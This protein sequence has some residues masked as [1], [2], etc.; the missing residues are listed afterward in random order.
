MT[1]LESESRRVGWDIHDYPELVEFHGMLSTP[2]DGAWLGLYHAMLGEQD[3]SGARRVRLHRP[4]MQLYFS[5]T[6]WRA[7]GDLVRR[8]WQTPELQ[9]CLTELQ[10]QYGEHG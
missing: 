7:L 1:S 8:A 3:P 4:R 6:E 5:E 2:A 9:Q 10:Q